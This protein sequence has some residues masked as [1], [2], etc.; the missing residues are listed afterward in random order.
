[1]EKLENTVKNLATLMK[2]NVDPNVDNTGA[3]A[4]RSGTS[5]QKD[6]EEQLIDLQRVTRDNRDDFYHMYKTKSVHK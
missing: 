3:P 5:K 1:M 2:K 4:N 6:Q